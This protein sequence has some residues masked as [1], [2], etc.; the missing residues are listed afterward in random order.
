MEKYT[1]KQIKDEQYWW[2]KKVFGRKSMW[3]IIFRDMV[4][5]RK[6]PFGKDIDLFFKKLEKIRDTTTKNPITKRL[7]KDIFNFYEDEEFF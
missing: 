1:K 5:H 4:S 2:I 3:G 6:D 7:Y